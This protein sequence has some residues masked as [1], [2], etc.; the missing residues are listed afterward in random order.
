MKLVDISGTIEKGMWN[1]GDELHNPIFSGPKITELATVEHDGFSAHKIELSILTSTYLETPAHLLKGRKTIDQLS[2]E[3]LFLPASVIKLKTKPPASHITKKELIEAGVKVKAG[4]CLVIYTGW[5]KRWN[6]KGFVTECPH[7]DSECMDWIV[8][9]NIKI[10][11]S[12]IPC[13]DDIQDPSDSQTLP[14]L[15]KLYFSGAMAL[16]P[17]VNGNKIKQG[18][19]KIII[20]PL[21]VKSFSASP[22]RAILIYQ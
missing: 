9:K 20:L 22:A 18:R 16:A 8:S 5:Y 4:D 1:Y 19:A 11:A 7:F 12:D 13:Y 10:L 17:V 21:K 15:R 3:E 2:L 6:T 14:Q